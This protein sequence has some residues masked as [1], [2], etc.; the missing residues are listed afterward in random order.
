MA[1]ARFRTTLTWREVGGF[2]RSSVRLGTPAQERFEREFAAQVLG[3]RRVFLAP[4]GRIALYWVLAGMGME[5]GDEVITQAFNF[6]AVP[7]AIAAAGA[8]PR[9]VDLRRDTFEVDPEGL[10][11]LIG[12]RTRAV[13]VTHLYGNP[14][15][16]GPLLDVCARHGVPLIEDVAQAVGATWDGRPLGTL[17][18]ACTFTFGPTKNLTL[19]GGAAAATADPELGSA[20]DDLSRRHPRASVTRS[21]KLAA[22]AAVITAATHPVTFNA[23]TLPAIRVLGA[24]G[25]DPVHRVMDEPAEPL[26]DIARAPL[27]SGPMA[28]V[29]LTQLRRLAENNEARARNGW[30]LRELL[31]GVEGVT[32]PPSGEGNVFLSFPVFHPRREELARELRRH[33][34]DTDLGFMCDCSQLDLFP[35]SRADCP[36]SIRA[37][38]EIIHL[39]VH[40]GLRRR[41]V[42]RMAERLRR[43]VSRV[44]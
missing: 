1:M 32:L 40:A 25:H 17:G 41:D 44:R 27:P 33:G 7:A 42:E 30:L 8:I 31:D 22:T 16:M 38:D 34:V 39:P 26:R 9:F 12:P 18:H 2:V 14:A 21:L 4:S 10:D 3:N 19:L 11:R 29:G 36:E 5:D 15:E 6:P 23:L 24:G 20:I 35:R 43:A 13:I 28:G 37:A